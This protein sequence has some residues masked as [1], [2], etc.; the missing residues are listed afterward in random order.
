MEKFSKQNKLKSL[1]RQQTN[2]TKN[3]HYTKLAA[4]SCITFQKGVKNG[5]NKQTKGNLTTCT[6][7]FR[8]CVCVLGWMESNVELNS[9]MMGGKAGSIDH[10]RVFILGAR[11]F[12]VDK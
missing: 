11:L 10:I 7:N 1:L 6:R 2:I 3:F 4:C 8:N 12:K 9:L 5:F